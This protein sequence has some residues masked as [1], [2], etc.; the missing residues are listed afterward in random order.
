MGKSITIQ[1]NEYLFKGHVEI[2]ADKS[3]SHR[4]VILSSLNS[5]ETIIN[6][7]LFSE[8]ISSTIS[9]FQKMGVDFIYSDNKLIVKSKGASN[10]SEAKS[11][12]DCGNSGTTARLLSGILVGQNF[13]SILDGDNSL[14]RRPMKRIEE[15]LRTMKADISTNNGCLPIEIKPSSLQGGE[16]NLN[17]G[18]AQVKSA[19]LFAGL[20]AEGET[21]FRDRK[22][23]RNHTEIMLANFTENIV[24]N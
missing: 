4:A 2:P 15:P 13:S 19:I 20:Y 12:L 14:R 8:D 9:C 18:S 21:K 22:R 7:I 6:N 24:V 11:V 17:L 1:G 10:F 3:I 5:T 16:F 23:S